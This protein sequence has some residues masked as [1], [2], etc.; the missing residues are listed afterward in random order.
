[1]AR[2]RGAKKLIQKA[3]STIRAEAKV[4]GGVTA[5]QARALETHA[6]NQTIRAARQADL[7]AAFSPTPSLRDRNLAGKKAWKNS[8]AYKQHR[9][10]NKQARAREQQKSAGSLASVLKGR[11]NQQAAYESTQ[12]RLESAFNGGGSAEYF[13]PRRRWKNQQREARLAKNHGGRS[14]SEV[15]T[16]MKAA[17]QIANNSDDMMKVADAVDVL[18]RGKSASSTVS[19]GQSIQDRLTDFKVKRAV[20]RH[21]QGNYSGP[22]PRSGSGTSG[23]KQ[24]GQ[25]NLGA[26]IGDGSFATQFN[27]SLKMAG[28]NIAS[29]VGGAGGYGAF[30]GRAAMQGAVWGGA[31]G[32]TVSAA[33]GGDFWSGA[34]EGAFKGA[35]GVAGYRTLKAA[36][37]ASNASE[38]L[39]NGK[40]IWAHHGAGN[41]S[42][43]VVALERLNQ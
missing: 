39:G 1:M 31:I 34:K 20:S 35:V 42:K 9:Q 36:T 26:A 23:T 25:L 13:D 40:A 11:A 43:T 16:E 28:S 2:G 10:A 3:A 33:Q 4:T 27:G 38:I 30:Y 6:A 12:R 8:D 22:T 19:S 17:R 7:E 24:T 29:H 15:A 5:G 21:K 41:K 14:A 32:G 37:K 18:K